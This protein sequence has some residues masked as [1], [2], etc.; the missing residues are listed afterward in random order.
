MK[1]IGKKAWIIPDC[2]RPPEGEGEMKGHESFI[3][4]NDGKKDAHIKVKLFFDD[5]PCV[6]GITWVVPAQSVKC[7]RSNNEEHMCGKVVPVGVQYAVKLTSDTNI[8]VQ[9]GKLDNRQVNLAY[10]TTM[11]F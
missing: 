2:D 10:Y 6:E 5:K 9:Y 4:V 7:F 3:I 11:S 8:V 1:V